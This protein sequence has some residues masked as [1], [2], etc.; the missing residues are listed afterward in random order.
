MAA[1]GE[2]QRLDSPLVISIH[3]RVY[4]RSS[5]SYVG[6]GVSNLS[7]DYRWRVSAHTLLYSGSYG[8]CD[9]FL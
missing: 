5:A 6:Y 9:N 7:G 3:G 1:R 4:Y 2:M 8:Y